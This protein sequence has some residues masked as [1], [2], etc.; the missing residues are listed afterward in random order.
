MKCCRS[1]LTEARSKLF[2]TTKQNA[3]PY[4]GPHCHDY[5]AWPSTFPGLPS[6]RH[7]LK[8]DG[9]AVLPTPSSVVFMEAESSSPKDAVTSKRQRGH[10]SDVL[11]Y[12]ALSMFREII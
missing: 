4:T 5:S 2:A 9:N 10:T 12:R 11:T 1:I 8:A 7:A 3:R 6:E